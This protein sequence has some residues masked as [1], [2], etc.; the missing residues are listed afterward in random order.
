VTTSE[1]VLLFLRYLI[2]AFCIAGTSWGFATGTGYI[3]VL[4]LIGVV[5]NVFILIKT[6]RQL[7]LR[8]ESGGAGKEKS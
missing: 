4:G 8:R 7:R 1:K 2:L 6:N 3:V 5:L